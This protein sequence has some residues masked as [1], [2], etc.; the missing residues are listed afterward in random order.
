MNNNNKNIMGI[1]VAV[2]FALI[3]LVTCFGQ[4]DKDVTHDPN[5]FL[6]YSDSFWEWWA[7]Q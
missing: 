2:I 6:G 1:I 5:G 4:E 7:K 3:T